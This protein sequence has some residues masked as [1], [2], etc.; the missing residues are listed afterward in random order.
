MKIEKSIAE[1]KCLKPTKCFWY[2]KRGSECHV[3]YTQGCIRNK[4]QKVER[5]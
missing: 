3:A 4:A 5:V 1:S 2:H